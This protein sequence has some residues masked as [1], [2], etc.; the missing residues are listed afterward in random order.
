MLEILEIRL[1]PATFVNPFTVQYV[2]P[3]GDLVEVS[4]SVATFRENLRGFVFESSGV[5]EEL[6]ELN[7]RASAAGGRF[8]IS[9][10]EQGPEGDGAVAVGKIN[11]DIDLGVVRV[12]GSL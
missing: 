9:V 4:S 12:N 10:V 7:L 5:G 3:D 1:A 6:V 2:E 8:K 11:A